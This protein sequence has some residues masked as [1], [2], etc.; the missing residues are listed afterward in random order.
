MKAETHSIA[1][2]EHIADCLARF[3]AV[4]GTT[5]S[6]CGTLT[7]ED[8]VIQSMPDVSPTKWHLA[9][10]TWFFEE[11]VLAAHKSDYERYHSGYAYLF[12]SYY[13]GI[14][15]M[16]PR[17]QRGLLSR[18]TVSETGAYRHSVDVQVSALLRGPE[19]TSEMVDLI[20]LGTHHEQQHQELLLMDIKH[21]LSM[22]PLLPAFRPDP[23]CPV[24]ESRELGFVEG[25]RGVVET[26]F[27][28]NG[29]HYDNEQPRHRSYLHPHALGDRLITN[30]EYLEFIRDGAYQRPEFWLSDGWSTLQRQ[31]WNRPLYW[32][33]SLDAQFTLAG[34]REL[35]PHSPVCHV[36]Y[37][38][39]DAYARWAGARLPTET[40]WECLASRYTG[41]QQSGH[42]QEEGHLHPL[43]ARGGAPAQLFGDAWE[44]TSSAYSS[45]PGYRPPEGAIGEY[46]GKFM[47]NQMVLRG[48]ACVTPRDHM[49]VSYRNFFY[50]DARWPFAGIRLARDLS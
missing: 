23:A 22:N 43:P 40:E 41:R 6:L 4:R 3:N 39:A 48:G 36:S 1:P 49:R 27:S 5:Q 30:A 7:P 31:G 17:S 8:Q 11:F 35:D 37:Y 47:C 9:H 38:E 44:W 21:V 50:P 32:S 24:G 18:P 12:N 15:D 14:G 2:E 16:H 33:A 13:N 42:F 20:L 28:G 25:E 26:G 45:Y 46:N 29:F 34:M 19:C 10:T